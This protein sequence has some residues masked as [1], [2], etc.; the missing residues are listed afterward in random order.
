MGTGRRGMGRFAKDLIQRRVNEN[1]RKDLIGSSK[2]VAD[3]WAQADPHMLGQDGSIRF[4]GTPLGNRFEDSAKIGYRNMLV[5]ETPQDLGQSRK[6][7]SLRRLSHQVG[8]SRLNG[9][10]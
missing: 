10:Q 9:G 5:E 3:L 6:R 2:R 1:H 4:P 7:H 8:V